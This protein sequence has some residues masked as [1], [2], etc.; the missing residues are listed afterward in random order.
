[1]RGYCDYIRHI[2]KMRFGNSGMQQCRY[3]PNILATFSLLEKNPKDVVSPVEA[4]G[5][6]AKMSKHSETCKINKCCEAEV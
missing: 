2:R 1:M 3:F 6:I 5:G 4:I